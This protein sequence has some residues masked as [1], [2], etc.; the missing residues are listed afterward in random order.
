MS[1]TPSN[2]PP[3]A[4]PPAN[5]R[6]KKAVEALLARAPVVTMGSVVVSGGERVDYGA[7]RAVL[8]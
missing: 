8:P 7:G 5:E 1:D 6:E 4:A 2:D 3:K